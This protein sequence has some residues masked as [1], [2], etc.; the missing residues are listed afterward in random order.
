MNWGGK[1]M[2]KLLVFVCLMVLACCTLS[3]QTKAGPGMCEKK[4][5]VLLDKVLEMWNKGNLAVIPELYTSRLRGHIPAPCPSLRRPRGDQ[6]W[7]EK[8]AHDV[9]RHGHDLSRGR[10]AGRQDRHGLD[11]D[12]DPDRAHAH[13]RQAPC[14]PPAARSASPACP[15]TSSR[16]ARWSRR[17]S[18]SMPWTC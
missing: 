5:Q 8:L 13:A 9:A 3:A 16:T 15:S 14:R 7:I 18:S 1:R 12:R 10:G 2:K 11:D 17:S 4:A 6:K